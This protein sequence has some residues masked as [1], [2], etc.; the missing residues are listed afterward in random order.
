M[1]NIGIVRITADSS[2]HTAGRTMGTTTVLPACIATLPVNRLP[3]GWWA[4]YDSCEKIAREKRKLY[5]F[6][7]SD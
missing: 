1:L 7:S 6:D 5:A 2:I 3:F 4:S